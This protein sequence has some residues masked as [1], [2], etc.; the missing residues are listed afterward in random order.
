M[1]NA[2]LENEKSQTVLEQKS[3]TQ[4]A[5]K[6]QKMYTMTQFEV[7]NALYDSKIFSRLKLT[8][9][10]K[11]VLIALARHFNPAK[12]DFFPSYSCISEHTGISKKSVERGIKELSEAKLISYRTQKVNRYRFTP[13]FFRMLN[14]EDFSIDVKMSA[15]ERQNV[16]DD[17]RQNVAQTNKAEKRNKKEAGFE[18]K[19]NFGFSY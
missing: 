1:I 15:D 5:P 19:I 4:D 6:S 2:D 10:A 14:L 3:G 9:G 8:A 11:L 13:L 18:E 12:E 16:C 7:I 17:E